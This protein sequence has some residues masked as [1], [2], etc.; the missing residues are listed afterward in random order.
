MDGRNSNDLGVDCGLL[1]RVQT[2]PKMKVSQAC[3][4]LIK[5]YEG[6]SL[7]PYRCPAGL[8]TIGFGHLIGDG[9]TLPAFWNRLFSVEEC[10]ALLAQ[11]VAR[12]E[13][14]VSAYITEPMAQGE[15]DGLVSFA[16]NLGLGTLQ[17]STVRQRFNRGD[18]AGAIEVLLKYNK[19]KGKVERGLTA[20]RNSEAQLMKGK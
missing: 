7:R 5:R 11:D 17:R 19:S 18:K 4:D 3:L 9:R 14:G 12:F 13:R 16:F 2:F 15:F 6:L 8:W 10:N 20:R 1:F